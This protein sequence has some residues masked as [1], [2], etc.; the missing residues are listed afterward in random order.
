MQGET[1]CISPHENVCDTYNTQQTFF[2]VKMTWRRFQDVLEDEKLL[3]F[4]ITKTDNRFGI[5]LD[6][7]YVQHHCNAEKL[8][9]YSHE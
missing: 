8:V 5:S 7:G 6:L 3:S 2:L 9:V 1:T 4:I